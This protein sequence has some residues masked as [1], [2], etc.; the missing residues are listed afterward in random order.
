MC[1]F[2][3]TVY[4]SLDN[5]YF[6]NQESC[7]RYENNLLNGL[8]GKELC[9]KMIS[10]ER[11]VK[12]PKGFTEQPFLKLKIYKK[13]VTISELPDFRYIK[14][15]QAKQLGQNCPEGFEKISLNN[16]EYFCQYVEPKN[17][18]MDVILKIQEIE[19]LGYSVKK[20]ILYFSLFGEALKR[21]EKVS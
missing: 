14:E 15:I 16:K 12:L 4:Q 19:S 17:L 9:L 3:R 21:K 6:P 5:K 20:N 7:L 1:C 10:R 11:G 8:S 18:I 13:T 2:L